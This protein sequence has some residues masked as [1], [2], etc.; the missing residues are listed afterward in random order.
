MALALTHALDLTRALAG[1]DDHRRL[2]PVFDDAVLAPVLWILTLILFVLLACLER[3]RK[4]V[5]SPVLFVFWMLGALAGLVPFFSAIM[6]ELPESD[7]TGFAVVTMKYLLATGLFICYCFAEFHDHKP[8]GF[9]PEQ[10]SSM[11]GWLTYLWLDKLVYKGFRW[12]L[13]D[14]DI[15]DLNTQDVVSRSIPQFLH[16]WDKQKLHMRRRKKPQSWRA[17]VKETGDVNHEKTPLLLSSNKTTS[18]RRAGDDT[19]CYGSTASPTDGTRPQMSTTYCSP[20]VTS[21]EV[22]VKEGADDDART[23]DSGSPYDPATVKTRVSFFRVMMKCFLP[24]LAFTGSFQ[25]PRLVMDIVNPFVLGLLINFTMDPSEPIWHGYVFALVLVLTRVFDT[26]FN[27]TSQFLTSRLATRIRSTAIAAV[28]RKAL[29][30]S[31]D[32]RKASTMGEIINLMAVDSNQLQQLTRNNY[33]LW[34][35]VFYFVAGSYFIYTIVGVAL[36]AGLAY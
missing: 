31:S 1:Q 5:K 15:F 36:F 19:G 20:E 34:L 2:H 9:S 13:G 18:Q 28:F 10:S 21:A 25:I 23:E 29:T 11:L 7:V 8:P 17:V 26:V 27:M 16:E 24:D 35:S 30:M 14:S 32:A 12:P 3:S 22:Q 4:V 33:W 6:E